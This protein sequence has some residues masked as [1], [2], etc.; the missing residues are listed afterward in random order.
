M[1]IIQCH[2]G[3]IHSERQKCLDSVIQAYRNTPRT[4]IDLNNYGPILA[5]MMRDLK[6]KQRPRAFRFDH[7]KCIVSLADWLSMWLLTQYGDG[8]RLCSDISVVEPWHESEATRA[9]MP[10]MWRK[11]GGVADYAVTYA[12]RCSSFFRTRLL[13]RIEKESFSV[14]LE[15]MCNS[16]YEIPNH[17]F[18]H[19][20]CGQHDEKHWQKYWDFNV[21]E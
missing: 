15:F 7:L 9:G 8:L 10:Y 17:H 14:P 18:V 4:F 6:I 12:N 1:H 3:P 2:F 11:Q 5:D 20:S 19:L 21:N 13:S 16:S